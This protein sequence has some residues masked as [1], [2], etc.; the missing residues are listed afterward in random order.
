MTNMHTSA[1]ELVVKAAELSGLLNEIAE[2]L[3]FT[4]RHKLDGRCLPCEARCTGAF[5]NSLG[6]FTGWLRRESLRRRA[7]SRAQHL[8]AG[9]GRGGRGQRLHRLIK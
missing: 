2:F 9:A 3:W 1:K 7:R 4:S 5:D 8:A 6:R